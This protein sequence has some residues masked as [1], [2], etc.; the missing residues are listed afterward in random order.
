MDNASID[1]AVSAE[2]VALADLVAHL[3]DR[4]WATPSLCGA[5]TVRDVVAHLTGTTRDGLGTILVAAVR[6]RGSFD[7]MEVDR[8]ARRAARHSTA[9]LVQMLRESAASTRRT[10]GSS[11]MDPL[12]DLVIHAQDIARPLGLVHTSPPDV[13]AASLAYVATNRFVG[14]P[15]RLRGLRVVSTDTGWSYGHGAAVRGTD[16]DLLLAVSG[17]PAGLLALSGP[18]LARLTEQL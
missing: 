8:A 1:G 15:K 16:L 11:R 7:R 4:Q 17:R 10:P 5:W 3:D 12:M 18:G 6:A 2:R 13:V 14:A 9:E